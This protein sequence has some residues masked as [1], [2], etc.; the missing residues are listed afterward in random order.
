M[1]LMLNSNS[2]ASTLFFFACALI[3][4]GLGFRD[5]WPPMSLDSHWSQKRW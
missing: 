2:H 4:V 1:R 5:A 3:F